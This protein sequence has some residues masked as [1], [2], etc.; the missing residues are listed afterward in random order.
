MP[1]PVE[2]N[3]RRRLLFLAAAGLFCILAIAGW[4]TL[5]ETIGR[6]AGDFLYPYLLLSRLGAD[7]LSDQTLLVFSRRELAE[8]L[9]LQRNENRRLA[10]Q[11]A[12]AAELLVEND[13]LRQQLK[14]SPPPS[15]H[16]V[17]AEIILR[18]PRF[19]NERLTVDRGSLDGITPGA[20]VMTTTADGGVILVG[21]VTRVTKHSAEVIT[22]FNPELRISAALPL[23]NAVGIVNPGERLARAGKVDIGFL[24]VE[25]NYVTEEVLQTT[26]FERQIPPGIKIGNLASIQQ[27]DSLFSSELYLRGTFVPAVDLNSSRFVVVADRADRP[28]ETEP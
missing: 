2:S 5:R 24:P 20:A 13:Q 11:S 4:S 27:V 28:Q 6:V 19:W 26:G 23:S 7:R 22:V 15:W 17:N 3:I 1:T 12:A 9:E 16:Y 18:D 21:V 8:Q 25:R 14:L 10:A